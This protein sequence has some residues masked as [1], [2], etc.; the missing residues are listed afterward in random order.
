MTV[1]TRILQGGSGS[2]RINNLSGPQ[3]T[4]GIEDGEHGDTH[5]G[6]DSKPHRG[7][8]DGGED[9]NGNLHA[10]GEDHILAGNAER[11]AGDEHRPAPAQGRR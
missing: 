5:V 4:H 7:D 6:K 11:P 8:A 9:E 3:G 2:K 1:F 10:D